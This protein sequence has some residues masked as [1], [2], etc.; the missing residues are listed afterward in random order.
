MKDI[1]KRI[2][3]LICKI[4]AINGAFFITATVAFFM[5]KIPW[6]GWVICSGAV[7]TYRTIQKIKDLI[8]SVKGLNENS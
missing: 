8:S 3:I 2:K 5:D 1:L 4:I 7:L 6:W